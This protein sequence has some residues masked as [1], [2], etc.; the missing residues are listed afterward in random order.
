MDRASAAMLFRLWQHNQ[1][2]RR[3]Q[4]HQLYKKLC[5]CCTNN[6]QTIKSVVLSLV[7][8]HSEPYLP[9]TM[10]LDL[11]DPLTN[12][13]EKEMRDVSR[14]ELQKRAEALFEHLSVSKE[15]VR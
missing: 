15:Q 4:Q 13:Y 12:L 2:R 3:R 10:C 9:Q 1:E 7:R 14:N 11:P 5:Q 6:G 8:E